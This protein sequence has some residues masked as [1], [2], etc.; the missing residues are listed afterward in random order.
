VTVAIAL[1]LVGATAAE[2]L[3]PKPIESF[4]GKAWAGLALGA[5][6]D[7]EIKQKYQTEKGAI[8]PEALRITTERDSGVRVDALLD[9]RGGKAVMRA[10]RVEFEKPPSLDQLAEAFGEKPVA[11]YNRE[12]HEDWR[13]LA[14]IDRGV[15]AMDVQGKVDT[16]IL[17]S[18]DRVGDAL[19]V[20]YDQPSPVTIPSDPGRNW[21][22]ILRFND[23]DVT[24]SLGSNRPSTLD[25]DWRR[26]VERRLQNEGESTRRG[27]LRYGSSYTGELKVRV[28]SDKFDK[29]GDSNFTV[30]VSVA[31]GS[32]YGQISQSASASKKIWNSYERRVQDL[33]EDAMLDLDRDVRGAIQK[34]GP[35]PKEQLRKLAMEKVY[36]GACSKAGD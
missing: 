1:L 24:V 10:I 14:F 20:F 19:N 2:R 17:C 27:S 32:P 16:F 21:D 28:S 8:R 11:M 23:V 13:I 12:R 22:R 33:Y 6:T 30:S 9:G 29:D 18:P 36:S 3:A 7:S 31:G 4:D 26:R 35:P 34:L 25:Y 15:L 5:L